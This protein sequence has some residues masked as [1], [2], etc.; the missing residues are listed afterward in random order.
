VRALLGGTLD[1]SLRPAFARECADTN[2]RRALVLLP[3][4]IVV[5]VVHM[6]IFHTSAVER[7]AL[8][9]R[10]LVWRDGIVLTHLVT[11]AIACGLY[12]VGRSRDRR[13]A[14]FVGPATALLY[15]LH[16]A[17]IAGV[18][19]LAITSVTPFVGYCLASASSSPCRRLPRSPST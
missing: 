1:A 10:V 4:L 6:G 3:I 5:H 19:Q 18:D 8:P 15:L 16:G 12:V 14:A 13:A 9:A 17:F 7:A 2:R 11:F